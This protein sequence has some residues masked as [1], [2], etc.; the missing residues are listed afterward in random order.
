LHEAIK[1][2]DVRFAGARDLI[3]LSDGDDPARDGEYRY[4]IDEA[5]EQG[6][7]IHVIGLGNAD[8]ASPIRI[9]GQPLLHEGKEVK[10][11]LE[12]APLREIADRTRGTYTAA[13]TATLYL[14]KLYLDLVA[15][16]SQRE[17]SDD[18]LPVYR[19]HYLQFLMPAFVLLF[20]NMLLPDRL[21]WRA[22][23]VGPRSRQPASRGRQ[24]PEGNAPPG[25]GGLVQ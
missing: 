2:H 18:A 16:E 5:R 14:G 12:E 17:Q 23:G 10:T 20:M 9:D 13:R 8:E 11:R 4:G 3:L 1:A 21:L 19:Q 22:R 7:A 15:G 25:N 24:P 6:I